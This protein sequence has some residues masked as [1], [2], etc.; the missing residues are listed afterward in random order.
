MTDKVS[1]MMRVRRAHWNTEN[2]SKNVRKRDARSKSRKLSKLVVVM[3]SHKN[4]RS[5]V[6]EDAGGAQ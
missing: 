4:L 3:F 2:T 1:N 5:V 6:S